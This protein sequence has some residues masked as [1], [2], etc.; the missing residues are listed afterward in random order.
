M[1]SKRSKLLWVIVFVSLIF[2]SAAVAQRRS[3]DPLTPA[4]IDEIRDT[5]QEPEQRLKFYVKFARARMDLVQQVSSDAKV[6]DKPN[7]MRTR[8]QDFLD[9]YDELDENA[10]TFADRKNDIRKALKVVLEADTEFQSKLRALKDSAAAKPDDARQY[11]FLLSNAIE[12]VDEGA[13]DHRD[14]LAEQDEL[15]KK[16][17]L[18]KPQ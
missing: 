16:K 8:L 15:A 7:A 11:E 13:K 2:I 14:L 9:L 1:V 12:A 18:I 5:A 10:D 4:E 17:Q 3:R 6:T